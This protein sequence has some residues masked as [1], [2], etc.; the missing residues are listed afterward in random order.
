MG[1]R[2]AL[3]STLVSRLSP[4]QIGVIGF[5]A[6]GHLTAAVSNAE[7]RTYGPVDAADRESLRPEFAILLYPGHLWDESSPKRDLQLSPWVE[8]SG[9]A[10]PTL[11]IHAMDDPTDD[12]RHSMAYGRALNDAGVSGRHA[13]QCQGRSR[14]RDTHDACSH[15]QR[16]AGDRQEMAAKQRRV[17][18]MT[19]SDPQA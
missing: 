12:V 4:R 19:S 17:S 14:V 11:L 8:I 7:R 5:S 10:P 6:G 9:K 1:A 16:M 3:R 18:P 15:H 13:L 2:R